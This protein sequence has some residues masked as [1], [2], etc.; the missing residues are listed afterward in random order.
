MW[1][2]V[3]SL[4]DSLT[5]LPKFVSLKT[6]KREARRRCTREE[7]KHES[8]LFLSFSF[9]SSPS[10]RC[11][12][13]LPCPIRTSLMTNNRCLG[14]TARRLITSPTIYSCRNHCFCLTIPYYCFSY[15]LRMPIEEHDLPLE[16]WVF[17]LKLK[18]F[19]FACTLCLKNIKSPTIKITW[20]HTPFKAPQFSF[21]VLEITELQDLDWWT[22][23]SKVNVICNQIS[24]E[25]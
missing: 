10:P 7:M 6:L 25:Q 16:R 15:L 9:R 13:S 24:L 20:A 23:K 21:K 18:I 5:V 12:A 4:P 1:R 19:V 22:M 11:R 8:L 17:S 3:Q 14:A 2:H